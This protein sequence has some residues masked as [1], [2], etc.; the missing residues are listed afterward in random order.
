MKMALIDTD[1]EI[2]DSAR[3]NSMVLMDCFNVRA[4]KIEFISTF[5]NKATELVDAI[6]QEMRTT[7]ERV[8][9]DIPSDLAVWEKRLASCREKIREIK[10][11]MTLW[12]SPGWR[13]K[14][15]LE[16][17]GYVQAVISGAETTLALNKKYKKTA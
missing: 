16:A 4:N 8:A 9:I 11:N 1:S 7:I 5:Y 3:I 14:E 10:L 2:E 15:T 17:M 13:T 12:H 6:D